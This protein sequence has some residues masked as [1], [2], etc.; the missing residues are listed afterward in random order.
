M[1]VTDIVGSVTAMVKLMDSGSTGK[2]YGESGE[3]M[4]NDPQAS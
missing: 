1:L 4:V 3:F 2:Q